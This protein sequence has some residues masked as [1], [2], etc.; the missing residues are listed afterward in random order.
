MATELAPVTPEVLRWARESIGVSLDEAARRAGVPV[1]RIEAWE[2][3]E[4]EPTVAKL[5]ALAQ[6]YQRP[7]AV[8]FLPEPP[9]TF[10]AMRDFRRL[11]GRD[12]HSW[13]RALHKVFRRALDQQE[14]AVELIEDDGA[15]PSSSIPAVPVDTSPEAAGQLARQ[16]LGI[17]FN[18]QFSWRKPDE[19]F[20]GWLQAIEAFNVFVL[21][22][23]DVALEEMRGFSISS[24]PVPIIVINALDWPRG[25]VFT[26]LHEFAHLMLREGGLCD[27]FEPDSKEGREVEM[28]CNAVAGATLMPR[29]QFLDNEVIG[30][31]GV[32]YWDDEVLVQL[33]R[34]WGVSREA[35]LRRLVT[36]HRASYEFYQSKRQEYLAVYAA[37]RE[38]E[39]DK[40]RQTTGG[41]PPYRMAIRDRG[42]P[43]VRLVLDAYH[44]EVISASSASNLL[45]LKLKHLAALEREARA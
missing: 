16:V 9:L 23:S 31:P 34:R 13:S 12:D 2:L 17:T 18:E 29:E 39:R 5:R 30:P 36:L 11:P 10:D 45:S 33:S 6:L 26:L 1:E 37:Q 3:G 14:T 20:A 21:R 35:V 40:R 25:Q 15:T 32:R 7:L 27:L 43:Y 22:T 28:W 19:A 8:F 44:R 24:G 38:E 42:K 4:S 41:P